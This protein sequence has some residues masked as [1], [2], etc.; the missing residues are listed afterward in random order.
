MESQQDYNSSSELNHPY[1]ELFCIGFMCIAWT[2]F[3]MSTSN[4]SDVSWYSWLHNSRIC[5]SLLGG[6]LLIIIPF[7]KIYSW[8]LASWYLLL[9]VGIQS[10]HGYFE[11][12]KSVDFYNFIGIIFVLSAI[13]YNGKIDNWI[14]YHLPF[15]ILFFIF[16]LTVKSSVFFSSISTFVNN[17]SLMISGLIIGLAV[18]RISS[19]RYSTALKFLESKKDLDNMTAQVAHDLR[20]PLSALKVILSSKGDITE[21]QKQVALSAIQR[22]DD[23]SNNLLKSRAHSTDR[24]DD[25]DPVVNLQEVIKSVIHEKKIENNLTNIIFL[26]NSEQQAWVKI[27]RSDLESIISNILN[28]S[29]DALSRN[30]LIEVQIKE[31]ENYNYLLINDNGVGIQADILPHLFN[32]GATFNKVEGQGLGLY[33]AKKK[34]K[35]WGAE[36]SLSSELNKG[37]TVS[38]VFPKMTNNAAVLIDND[39]FIHYSWS[40]KAKEKRVKLHHYYSINE[41]ISNADQVP[42]NSDIYVDSDLGQSLPGEIESKKIFELGFRNIILATGF[43]DK[44]LKTTPWIKSIINK[45]PPF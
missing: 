43:N 26:N 15:H 38:I 22:M 8:N 2:L 23:I 32:R 3:I 31:D 5:M 45:S 6:I 25:A 36:I 28:N 30:G 34:L 12:N 37:T 7:T 17:F 27:H 18:L 39:K 29:L 40:I 33:F 11:S 20:S 21:E 9:S 24:R 13:S 14:K 1:F 41:F 4:Y 16:P 35:E 10:S 42:K 44:D 19:S